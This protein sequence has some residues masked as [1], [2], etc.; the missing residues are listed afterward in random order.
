MALRIVKASEPIKVERLNICIYGAPGL[1][2]TTLANTA[3][4]PITLDFDKGVHRAGIRKDSVIINNWSD[5][6]SLSQQDLEGYDTVVVDT[7]G[8][9]LDAMTIDIIAKNPK[10]GRAGGALSLQGY[11]ELKARFSAWLKLLNSFGKDVVLI[12]HMDEQKNGD[13]LIERLDI[14][15]GSKNEVY[16]SMDAMARIGINSKGQFLDFNPSSSSFGKNPAQFD[17]LQIPHVNMNP[18]FLSDV[19]SDIKDKLNALTAEQME[20]QKEL[21]NWRNSL[22]EFDSADSFNE[23]LATLKDESPAKK[24]IFNNVANEKGF[25]FNRESKLYE[26]MA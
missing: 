20:L 25:V 11:G 15:G 9:M 10:H 4:T 7:V 2:K 23:V 12:A 16:K 17:L 22:A 1:G 19:I 26:A 18:H 8:R 14:Q 13:D 3:S 6:A 24:A 5:I 21:D